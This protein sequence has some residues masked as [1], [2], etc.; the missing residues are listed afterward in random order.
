MASSV[1]RFLD[2]TQRRTTVDRTALDEWSA[3]RRDIYLTTHNTH[4]THTSITPVEFEPTISTG[5]RPQTYALD[6]AATGTGNY[7]LCTG[8]KWTLRFCIKM[9]KI[10]N[11]WAMV[12][13]S[14]RT[15]VNKFNY[16]YIL[17]RK[18]VSSY[19]HRSLALWHHTQKR[20]KD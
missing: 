15:P 18:Y 13:F 12:G 5:E 20:T 11:S 17:R 14:A 9:S 10:Y 1:T 16:S 2:H 3:R 8:S 6:S 4:N 7:I 19:K